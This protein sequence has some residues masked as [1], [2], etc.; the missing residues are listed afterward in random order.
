MIPTITYSYTASFGGRGGTYYEIGTRGAQLDG[1]DE[2]YWGGYVNNPGDGD[3]HAHS[4]LTLTYEYSSPMVVSSVRFLA[5]AQKWGTYN[6]Y[7][8][9]SCGLAVTAYDWNDVPTVVYPAYAIGGK[10]PGS[11]STGVILFTT[12]MI[13]VKKIVVTGYTRANGDDSGGGQLLIYDFQAT[14]AEDG[15]GVML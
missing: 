11:F 4:D 5:F 13:N 7:E 10:G 6:N 14:L 12:L 8:S 3:F 1:D 15:Y 2:T 9:C